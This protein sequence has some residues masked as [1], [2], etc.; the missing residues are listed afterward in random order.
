MKGNVVNEMRKVVKCLYDEGHSRDVFAVAISEGEK[1][2]VIVQVS[3]FNF[4]AIDL[5]ADFKKTYAQA[6]KM[7]Q[8]AKSRYGDD[9]KAVNSLVCNEIGE[10]VSFQRGILRIDYLNV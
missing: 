5:K 6:K 2:N 9:C 10:V 8:L 1:G 3:D 7:L 4:D